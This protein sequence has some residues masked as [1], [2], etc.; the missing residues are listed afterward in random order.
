ML[1]RTVPLLRCAHTPSFT[2]ADPA[3]DLSSCMGQY[4]LSAKDVAGVPDACMELEIV[5][6]VLLASIF[7]HLDSYTL[8][9]VAPAVCQRWK[10]VCQG[11]TADA[12][13]LEWAHASLRALPDQGS[14]LASGVAALTSATGERADVAVGTILARELALGG[15]RHSVLPHAMPHTLRGLRRMQG[16]TTLDLSGCEGFRDSSL[17]QMCA[18]AS[19]FNLTRLNLSDCSGITGPG[20]RHLANFPHLASLNLSSC[21]SINGAGLGSLMAR[22]QALTSLDLSDNEQL[23][24]M[25]NDNKPQLPW[26]PAPGITS[27]NLSGCHGVTATGIQ[28]IAQQLRGLTFLDLKCACHLTDSILMHVGQLQQLTTLVLDAEDCKDVTDTGVGHLRQLT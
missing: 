22:L 26:S 1:A 27:L 3:A 13:D 10:A 8:L 20:L 21:T 2:A 23:V 12:C 11:L 24:T 18:T 19:L 6:D 15:M 4:F 25:I 14:M 5:S 17:A 7:Q 16:V 9:M 28:N